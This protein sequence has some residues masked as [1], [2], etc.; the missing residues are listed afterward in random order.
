MRWMPF[1]VLA[2]AGIA[3]AQTTRPNVLLITADDMNYDTPGY[4]GGKVPE[5]KPADAA[6]TPPPPAEGAA[7]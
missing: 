5:M 4:A 7:H 1:L 3:V 2:L 6:M